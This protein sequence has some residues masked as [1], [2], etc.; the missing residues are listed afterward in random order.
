[1]RSTPASGITPPRFYPPRD[2]ECRLLHAIGWATGED[3]TLLY[4]IHHGSAEARGK[5]FAAF[6]SD[7]GWSQVKSESETAAG[8]SL[9]V[10]GGVKSE[11][12]IATDFSPVK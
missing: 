3:D 1:M 10:P 5:S 9:T 4:F 8:G 11:L 6:G 7:P 2:D 12:L